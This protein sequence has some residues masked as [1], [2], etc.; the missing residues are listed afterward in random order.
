NE[1]GNQVTLRQWI[2][3]PEIG[4]HSRFRRVFRACFNGY[5]LVCVAIC[6]VLLLPAGKILGQ[7]QASSATLS[8]TV[9]DKTGA[10]IPGAMVT[11]S[12]KDQGFQHQQQTSGTGLYAFTLLLPGQYS[13][14]V[15]KQG[16]GTFTE[17]NINLQVGQT[18]EIPVSLS[19]ASVAEQVTVT[20]ETP[21]LNTEDSNIST[22]VDGKA[23]LELPL[24]QRNIVSLTFLNAAVTNQA[25]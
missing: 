6:A 13:L 10:V 14:K 5:A 23:I 21:Q 11:L 12:S 9:T 24:N 1:G 22:F 17:T 18:Q 16:L 4:E 15:E 7:S 2:T 20:S 8:G 3:T 25:L 19:L